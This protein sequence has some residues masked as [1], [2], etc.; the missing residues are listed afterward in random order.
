MTNLRLDTS[1]AHHLLSFLTLLKTENDQAKLGEEWWGIRV[2]Y[3][4]PILARTGQC[5]I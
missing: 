2:V 1:A 4:E 5:K 3:N